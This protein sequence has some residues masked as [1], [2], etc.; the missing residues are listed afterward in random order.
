MTDVAITVPAEAIEVIVEMTVERVRAELGDR[1]DE[2]WP[3][4]MSVPTAARYLDI[5]EE[6]LRKLIGRR[7]VPFYQEGPGC[8]ISFCRSELDEWMQRFRREAREG[9]A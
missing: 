8:R 4:W 9:G 5:S 2:A 1:G 6:R 7:Q 3:E